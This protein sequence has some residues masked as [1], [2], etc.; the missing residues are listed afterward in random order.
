MIVHHIEYSQNFVKELRNLPAVIQN[1]AVKTEKLFKA[2]PLH[3]SLR[4]H[5]LQG[6]LD[7]L[8]SI[9]VTL[10]Y[11]I[12]FLRMPKGDVVFTSIGR[13]AIYR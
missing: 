12:I 1:R 2:N 8:W 7:S 3:P 6:K 4:L 11:R 9:S 5:R 10:D 13:H